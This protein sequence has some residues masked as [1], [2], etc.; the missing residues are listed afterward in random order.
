MLVMFIMNDSHVD[1]EPAL[2]LALHALL[3]ERS[4]TRAAKQMGVTQS[5]MSHTLKRLRERLNDP[6]LVGARNALLLTPRAEAMRLPLG[7]ALADLR[8]SLAPRDHFDPRTSTRTFTIATND[9]GE[10]WTMQETLARLRRDAPNVSLTIT[11]PGPDTLDALTRGPVDLMIGPPLEWPSSIKQRKL[12]SET[13]MV[14]GAAN[15]PAFQKKL[16]L[17]AYLACGH[18]VVVPKGARGSEVDETLAKKGLARR[19][20]LRTAN[21]V[22]AP[23]LAAQSD[24]LLTLPTGLMRAATRHIQ[25]SSAA[26]PFQMRT[27]DAMMCWHERL[28]NDPG[29]V[30]LRQLALKVVE[31]V[32]NTD[33]SASSHP[34]LSTGD[35]KSPQAAYVSGSDAGHVDF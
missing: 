4:V 3:T 26:T 18:L 27:V 6:L 25:L 28:H 21:F 12:Y 1:I 10:F 32:V 15:H 31:N 16:T 9:Y 7:R 34:R 17:E 22:A 30:W 23:F 24:L 13:F 19:I 33:Q 2:L 35:D 29:H 11:P 14:V 5:A 20:I 8:D